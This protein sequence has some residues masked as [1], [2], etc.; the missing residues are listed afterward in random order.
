MHN[1]KFRVVAVH[2]LMLV[3][4]P[5]AAEP[6]SSSASITIFPLTMQATPE[7]PEHGCDPPPSAAGL[8][9][10]VSTELVLTAEVIAIADIGLR[11]SRF[12]RLL[13]KDAS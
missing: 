9:H 13:P 2:P 10:F 12:P 7:S 6:V 4:S 1:G 8:R 3:R 5:R 11:G